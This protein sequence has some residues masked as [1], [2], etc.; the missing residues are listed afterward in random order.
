MFDRNSWKQQRAKCAIRDLNTV[1]ADFNLRGIN[2]HEQG[3]DR[4][5]DMQ[6]GE[7]G[8]F[9]G[10]ETRVLHRGG[11][12]AVGDHGGK[13]LGCG[14]LTDASAQAPSQFKSDERAATLVE[15]AGK[16][17]RAPIASVNDCFSDGSTR[18]IEEST[19]VKFGK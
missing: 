11:Y 7:F 16:D 15:G 18:D 12:G 2:V 5:L 9:N 8:G 19:P 1:A 10:G 17:T 14:G 6:A 4:D 13:C 3:E